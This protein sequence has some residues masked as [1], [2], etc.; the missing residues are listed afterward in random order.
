MY[1]AIIIGFA[2]CISIAFSMSRL[3]GWTGVLSVHITITVGF[4]W[5]TIYGFE[6][7]IH[8]PGYG[9]GPTLDFFFLPQEM[10]L[11]ALVNGLLFI[12]TGLGLYTRKRRRHIVKN[13]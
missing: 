3:F 4:F 6:K 8:T 1:L 5:W 11:V 7:A 13:E 12:F 2:F 10:I 9:E